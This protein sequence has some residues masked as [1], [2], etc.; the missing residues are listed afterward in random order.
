MNIFEN[1]SLKS[2]LVFLTLLSSCV[3]LLLAFTLFLIYDEHLL[4]AH[5]EEELRSA[6]D[7]IGTNSAAALVFGDEAEAEKILRALQTRRNF[8]KA[9][10]Y[11]TDGTVLST[12]LR[13]GVPAEFPLA[14]DSAGEKVQWQKDCIGLFRTVIL[15]KPIIGKL[16]LEAGLEDLREEREHTAWLA[17]SVFLSTL[18]LIYFLTLLLQRSITRPICGKGSGKELHKNGTT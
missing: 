2:R 7:L 1:S 5:K 17:I 9:V 4:R 18:L 14:K 8:R 10:L 16:Y 12:Y 6:A 3:G 13:S 11:R 15:D